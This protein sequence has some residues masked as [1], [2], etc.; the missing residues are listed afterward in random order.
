MEERIEISLE[1]NSYNK[2]LDGSAFGEI[3]RKRYKFDRL[4][5]DGLRYSIVVPKETKCLTGSYFMACFGK[6]LTNLGL[7]GFKEKYNFDCTNKIKTNINTAIVSLGKFFLR[8]D[9]E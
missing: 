4:D 1:V 2:M 8:E 5:S 9:E 3:A 6:S 7:K